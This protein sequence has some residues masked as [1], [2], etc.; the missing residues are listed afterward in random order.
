MN[1]QL[2]FAWFSGILV[3]LV[4]IELVA[5]MLFKIIA[6]F[7]RRRAECKAAIVGDA[8]RLIAKFNDQAYFEARDRVRGRCVDGA[9]SSRHWTRVKLEIAKR[10]GIAIG[11]A[12]ADM[13]A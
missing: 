7:I 12:G 2:Y 11:L 9:G 13:R 4:L 1:L 8:E 3:A 6:E 5:A 10:K